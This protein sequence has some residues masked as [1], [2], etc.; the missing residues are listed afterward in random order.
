M[1]SKGENEDKLM[2][3]NDDAIKTLNCEMTL[4]LGDW[5][6]R[7][8]SHSD[9]SSCFHKT[10]PKKRKHASKSLSTAS[11][12]KNNANELLNQS[13]SSSSISSRHSVPSPVYFSPKHARS[14]STNR[15]Q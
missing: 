3:N 14:L 12:G 4:L 15:R 9:R 8:V 1:L 2:R 5:I 7:S 13:Y 6:S 11:N 10:R